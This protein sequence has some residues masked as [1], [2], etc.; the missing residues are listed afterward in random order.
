[1]A[2][3]FHLLKVSKLIRETDDTVSV[4]FEIPDELKNEFSYKHGQYLT[5]KAPVDA[6]DN[7]RAYSI[8]SSPFCDNRLQVTVKRVAD[9]LV[10]SYINDK[11]KEGDSL[12]V[13]PPLGRFTFDLDPQNKKTYFL[14]GG[15]SGITPLMSIIKSIL[16]VELRS[17]VVLIYANRNEKSIIFKE[18]LDSLINKFKD[19]FKLIHIISQ[20]LNSWEGLKGRINSEL[21]NNLVNKHIKSEYSSAEYFMCGPS[22]MM[23][24]VE[25]TLEEFD[26]PKSNIHKESFT[27]PLN[28]EGLVKGDEDEMEIV[29]RDVKII[30]Y[31]DE[32]QVTVEPGDTVLTSAMYAGI[33]PPFSCQIGAC[34]TCRAKLVSGKVVMDERESLTDEEIDDGYILTCQSHPLTD[35]VVVNYDEG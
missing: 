7:R 8:S 15:G 3:S 29:T 5:I 11:L 6:V 18:E 27:A 24:M 17:K 22:G 32:H 31:G 10:S 30:L 14:V 2:I 28:E 21:F 9:G 25:S 19:R 16:T 34:S 23:K 4:V 1:M 13:M 35:D 20:P 12:E 33:D 26:V